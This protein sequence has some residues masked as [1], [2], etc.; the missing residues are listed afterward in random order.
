MTQREITQIGYDV[1]G[2]AIEVHRELG[3]GLLESVCEE[4]LLYELGERG[5]LVERQV[6][7][8]VMYKG[9]VLKSRLV[10]DLVVEQSIILEL[11]N[12]K[13]LH[14]VHTAQI[15]SYMNVAKIPKGILINF[16]TSNISRDT[17][18]FVNDYYNALAR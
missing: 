13:E 18:H 14:P 11:K 7:F 12:V 6:V 15:L 1:V 9:Q 10:V 16:F 5:L 4:S 17:K 2:A 8:P 3:P